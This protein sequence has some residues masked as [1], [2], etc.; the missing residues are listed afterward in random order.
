MGWVG[1]VEE[2]LVK[3]AMRESDNNQTAA[4]KLIGSNQ[5]T[6]GRKFKKYADGSWVD[7]P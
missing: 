6:V 1:L 4:A 2:L 7:P 3:E 5:S